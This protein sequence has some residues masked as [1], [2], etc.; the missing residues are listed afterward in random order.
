MSSAKAVAWA[1]AVALAVT[2]LVCGFVRWPVSP[3]LARAGL[4][5]YSATEG[6]ERWAAPD[7]VTFRAL[8]WP[9]LHFYNARLDSGGPNLL[10]APEARIDLSLGQLLRGQFIPAR[11]TFVSPTITVDLDAPPFLL[12]GGIGHILNVSRA[13]APLINVSLEN[14]IVR[15]IDKRH[16]FDTVVEDV[17]GQI[18]GTG[19]AEG[20]RVN[21]SAVWRETPVTISGLLANIGASRG[22]GSDLVLGLQ[23]PVVDLAITGGLLLD[24]KPSLNGD[25]ALTIKSLAGLARVTGLPR[26]AFWAADDIAVMGKIKASAGDLTLGDATITSAGQALQGAL[27]IS[28]FQGRSV[29]SGTLDSGKLALG[30][31]I[32]SPQPWLNDEGGWSER[33]FAG[34]IPRDFDLDLRLSAG[35]LDFYGRPLSNAAASILLKGGE[36][37]L[38][39]IEAGAYGGRLEGEARLSYP[40]EALVLRARAKLRDADIGAALADLGVPVAT[41][42][43]TVEVGLAT[44]GTTA[45][46]AIAGLAGTASLAGQQGSILGVNLEEALRR[47]QRRP[48][49]VSRAMRTGQTAFDRIGVSA[50]IG[51]G[52][53]HITRG[54]LAARGLTADL[55]GAIDLPRQTLDLRLDAMQTD[56]SGEISKDAARLTLD[57]AGAWSALSVRESGP[58]EKA[59]APQ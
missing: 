1:G 13:L 39:L 15:I 36:F 11:T 49:D 34:S 50:L 51:G 40:G 27:R 59:P 26:P 8:P 31:L 10:Y 9:S 48:L 28:R 5:A 16:D 23:S 6:G 41:G 33:R 4:N 12:E 47:S 32:G 2:I 19:S 58:E 29:V 21:F 18:E 30:P 43:G 22:A 3:T 45:A 53:A 57:I 25:V 46:D 35:S 20:L 38:S 55:A 44:S 7:A 56:S 52:V 42:R 14:G 54:N 24:N 37:T 17:R